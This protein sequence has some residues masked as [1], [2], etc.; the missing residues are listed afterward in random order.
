MPPLP[1]VTLL[2]LT[3]QSPAPTVGD[4][5][6]M[7]RAVPIRAGQT[8]RAP[9]WELTGDVELLGPPVL[10]V[11]GDSA[12]VAYPL[13]AWVAG[14]HTVAVPSPIL[15]APDGAVDSLPAESRTF[16]VRSVLPAR[17][18]STVAPQP[19]AGIVRRRTVTLRPLALLLAAAV[20]LVLPLHWWWRRGGR[21]LPLPEIAR[22]GAP[23]VERWADAGEARAVLALAS[24]RLRGIVA[25]AVPEAHEGL[26]TEACLARV[27]DAR[28][29]W[30]L[31]ELAA[32][33]RALDEARF[34]PQPFPGAL[35]LHDDASALAARLADAPPSARPEAAAPGAGAAA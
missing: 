34:S 22:P 12:V 16:E 25:H 19:E 4:T 5:V 33:L 18:D 24:A 7:R 26:D 21:P 31:D 9:E 20:L 32:L 13:V 17:G 10:S 30:P 3:I 28:P 1:L 11:R 6:W 8:A 2:A 15:L 29:D 35:S 27:A 14:P 23:P